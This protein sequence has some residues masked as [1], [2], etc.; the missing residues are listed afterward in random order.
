MD[1]APIEPPWRRFGCPYDELAARRTSFI[2][3]STPA[4]LLLLEGYKRIDLG[5]GR[6]LA[7]VKKEAEEVAMQLACGEIN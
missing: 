3:L 7:D 5:I 1:Y 2:P 4:M 6:D